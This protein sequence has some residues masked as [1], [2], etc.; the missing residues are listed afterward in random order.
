MGSLR[1]LLLQMN[2]FNQG[3]TADLTRKTKNSMLKRRWIFTI[4]HYRSPQWKKNDFI[5]P[6]R[7]ALVRLR[8]RGESPGM[9]FLPHEFHPSEQG[10]FREAP[11]IPAD[12]GYVTIIRTLLA[13]ALELKR[14]IC[15][16]Q[17][18]IDCFVWPITY[19]AKV[20][21]WWWKIRLDTIN[22]PAPVLLIWRRV[23]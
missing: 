6:T 7:G 12:S 11:A 20:R 14:A 23:L 16:Y 1:P 8:R 21:V 15:L 3:K 22:P 13:I 18:A 10:S 19:K 9:G 2:W 5:S 17:G 4:F